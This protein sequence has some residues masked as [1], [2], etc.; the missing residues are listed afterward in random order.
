MK[1]VRRGAAMV[2]VEDLH[3]FSTHSPWCLS[4]KK[5]PGWTQDRDFSHYRGLCSP[6]KRTSWAQRQ[7]WRPVC[8]P[9]GSSG[10]RSLLCASITQWYLPR[11]SHCLL[12]AFTFVRK[13]MEWQ[14]IWALSSWSMWLAKSAF[15]LIPC[16]DLWS[17]PK[18]LWAISDAFTSELWLW[19]CH[20]CQ[21]VGFVLQPS[22]SYPGSHRHKG[23]SAWVQWVSACSGSC[24]TL[25]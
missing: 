1:K 3:A 5:N 10:F 12:F 6:T 9:P 4:E 20:Q 7:H 25:L 16:L 8:G 17:F 18:S 22:C 2:W 15:L 23:H 19:G 14:S 11:I 24:L 21:L 13:G